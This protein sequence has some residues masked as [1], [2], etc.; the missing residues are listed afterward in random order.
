MKSYSSRK[1]N[2]MIRQ[3]FQILR[4]HGKYQKQD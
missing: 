3:H 2:S 1:I 4:K